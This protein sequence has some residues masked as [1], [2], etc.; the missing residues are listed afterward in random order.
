MSIELSK[1]AE[2]VTPTHVVF[3]K[4]VFSNFHHCH[5]VLKRDRY[6]DLTFRNSEQLCMYLKAKH[7]NDNQT[8][9]EILNTSNPGLAKGLGRK[10][11]NFVPSQWEQEAYD[12]MLKACTLK[13]QQNKSLAEV[14]LATGD[15]VIV[16]ANGKDKKWSCGYYPNNPL[17]LDE[18]KWVGTNWLGKILT[19]VREGLRS[20]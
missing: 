18:T 13:F 16:E 8:A 3:L 10:V 12:T 1:Y 4:G 15:R 20:K 7:F 19:E 17:C 9:G 14:L 2:V 5:I 6:V 11:K